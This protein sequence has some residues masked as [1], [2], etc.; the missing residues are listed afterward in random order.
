[1]IIKR[2]A[3]PFAAFAS[4][5]IIAGSASAQEPPGPR[6]TWSLTF[7]NDLFGGGDGDYTNGVRFDYVSPRNRLTAMGRFGR[8][9]LGWLTDAGDWYESFA[10]GQNIYTP[11]DISLPVPEPDDRPYG[12]YLYFGYALSADRGDRLDTIEIDLGV[13]GPA[14]LA[15]QSQTLVHNII[16]A[17]DPKGWDTQIEN[18]PG[19]RIIYERKYRYGAD[20][21]IP[22][23]DLSVDAAPH[24]NIALGNVDTSAGVGGTVRF[25]QDLGDDYGPPRV[26]PAVSSPGFFRNEDDFSW[27][28]F[29][30]V[31]GRVVGRNIFLQGN[32]FGGVDGVTINR[33]VGDVQVG[34]ALQFGRVEFAYTHVIRTEEYAGQDGFSNFGSLNV[35]ARF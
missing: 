16:G 23:L 1:M 29:A 35:R 6:G 28:L 34:A 12:G 2:S 15:E 22:V 17:Q 27:Y 21:P 20:L 32:T 33:F 19:I 11:D 4:A 24:F 3:L 8:D 30:G 26:R 25:G 18:E 7:E 9:N 5:A 10:L 13:V 14:S 31:E